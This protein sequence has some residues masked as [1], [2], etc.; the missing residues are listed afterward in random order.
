MAVKRDHFYSKLTFTN[1][2]FNKTPDFQ[3]GF[4][5]NHLLIV[6]DSSQNDISFSFNGEDLDGELFKNNSIT[7]DWKQVNRIWFLTS[8]ATPDTE[9]RIWAWV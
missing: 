4:G 6:N 5:A 9:L 2:T 7:F 3:L 8:S 1:L